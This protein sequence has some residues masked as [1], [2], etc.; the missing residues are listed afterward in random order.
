MCDPLRVFIISPRV[1]IQLRLHLYQL[2]HLTVQCI[3]VVSVGVLDVALLSDPLG[4]RNKLG[5]EI[6]RQRR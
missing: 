5:K 1:I 4:M 6:A 3:H 2:C